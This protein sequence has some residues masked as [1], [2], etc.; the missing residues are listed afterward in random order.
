MPPPTL[1]AGSDGAA[2]S[3]YGPAID[4]SS[5]HAA[6]PPGSRFIFTSCMLI[7]ARPT[8]LVTASS[9]FV[10][11]PAAI[12]GWGLEGAETATGVSLGPAAG[13]VAVLGL[14]AAA[15]AWTA[16]FEGIFIRPPQFLQ[17]PARPASRSS[18]SNGEAHDGHWK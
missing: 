12:E 5:A 8:W 16:P 17:R 15:G 7:G 18:T 6:M 2:S 10:G 1:I 4:F 9:Q 11:R 13:A 3:L 14:P